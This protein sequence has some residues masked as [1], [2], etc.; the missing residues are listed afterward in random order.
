M[1]SNGN[2]TTNS[3][4]SYIHIFIEKYYFRKNINKK[5]Y[6]TL[7]KVTLMFIAQQKQYL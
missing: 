1:F 2:N 4:K 6:L 7:K 3:Y 5:Y